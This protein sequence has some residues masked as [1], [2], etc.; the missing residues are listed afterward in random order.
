MK[1]NSTLYDNKYIFQQSIVVTDP[2]KYSIGKNN[3]KFLF[4]RQSKCITYLKFY[5]AKS[6]FRF[7]YHV[8]VDN[9]DV[10]SMQRGQDISDC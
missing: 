2:V 3:I 1:W 7:I 8:S 9:G 5:I 6:F 4:K 10:E